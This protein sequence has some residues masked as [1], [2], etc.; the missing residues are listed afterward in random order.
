M[1]KCTIRYPVHYT[2][3]QTSLSRGPGINQHWRVMCCSVCQSHRDVCPQVDWCGHA[4]KPHL[5]GLEGLG[6]L[7]GEKPCA[8]GSFPACQIPQEKVGGGGQTAEV[9]RGLASQL[10]STWQRFCDTMYRRMEV[11]FNFQSL[12]SGGTLH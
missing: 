6:Y 9:N 3:L 5:A 4:R 10:F 11:T 2:R 1:K 8:Q 12:L 7:L